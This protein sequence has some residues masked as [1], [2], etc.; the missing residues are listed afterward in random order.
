MVTILGW[1]RADARRA[2]R[3][4]RCNRLAVRGKRGGQ[5]LDGNTTLQPRVAGA[6]NLAHPA[7]AKS[8]DDLIRPEFGARSH[9]RRRVFAGLPASLRFAP[10]PLRARPIPS[11]GSRGSL[12]ACCCEVRRER[13]SRSRA[14]SPWQACRKKCLA[15][16]RADAP[17]PPAAGYRLVSIDPIASSVPPVNSR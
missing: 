2:S 12:P 1:L 16:R 6:I 8:G 17:A 10:E 4:K 11:R 14:G 9:A 3:S 13:T 15:L 5:D 7:G